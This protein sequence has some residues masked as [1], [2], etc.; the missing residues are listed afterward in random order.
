MVYKQARNR[1]L[2]ASTGLMDAF[3]AKGDEMRSKVELEQH[4]RSLNLG[5]VGHLDKTDIIHAIQIKEG[6]Q[7]CFGEWCDHC[8]QTR[9]CWKSDCLAEF[10]L[11]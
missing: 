6:F 9:C 3:S 10:T 5:D 8:N 4:A 11:V 7:P 1:I 2:L